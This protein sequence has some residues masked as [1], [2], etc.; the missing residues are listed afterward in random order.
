MKK[1]FLVIFFISALSIAKAQHQMPISLNL[2]G[3]YT[4][5]DHLNLGNYNSYNNYGV[6]Q[7]GGQLGAGLEFY[8][9][10]LRSLELSYQYMGTHTPFYNYQGQ[11][12]SGSDKS[13]PELVCP[14]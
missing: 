5:Q 6:I 8:L 10:K 3:G 12:N 1:Y 9:N 7:A 13:E 4:F 11:T 14:W 2:Y